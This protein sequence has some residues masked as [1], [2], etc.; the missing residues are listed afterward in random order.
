MAKTLILIFYLFVLCDKEVSNFFLCIPFNFHQLCW[1]NG[2]TLI[3]GIKTTLNLIRTLSNPGFSYKFLLIPVPVPIHAYPMHCILS[4]VFHP[5]YLHEL[6]VSKLS[7]FSALDTYL[8][9]ILI[10]GG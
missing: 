10:W 5:I 1:Y 8:L 9:L 3:I 4:L 6:V 7:E 2:T